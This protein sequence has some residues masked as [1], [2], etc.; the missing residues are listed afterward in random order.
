MSTRLS[1]AL[2][3]FKAPEG[4]APAKPVPFEETDEYREMRRQIIESR[5]R[6]AGLRGTYAE[7]ACSVGEGAYRRAMDGRGTYLWGLPGRGKTY[8]AAAAVRMAVMAGWDA[9]L[10]TAKALLDAVKAE[11][12][13]GEKGTIYRAERYR[14]LALD[15]LGVERPTEWAMETITGLIDARV[16]SG[17]PTIVTSN[18]S[19]GELRDRWGGMPGMRIASRLGGACERIQM[20]GGDRRLA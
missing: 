5:L 12:D 10:V 3:G 2:K 4:V 16:A 13:G 18:F 1:E 15:D 6:K 7:A 8:A 9:R 11:W 20:G 19:L 17:L 14:L